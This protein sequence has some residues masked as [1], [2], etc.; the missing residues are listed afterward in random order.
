MTTFILIAVVLTIAAV[1]VVVVPLVRKG[2]ATPGPA[3]G[4]AFGA[5]ARD[6]GGRADCCWDR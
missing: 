2:G 3:I 6:C 4:A 5:A 1:G